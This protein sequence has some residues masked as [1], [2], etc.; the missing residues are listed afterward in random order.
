MCKGRLGYRETEG[1]NFLYYHMNPFSKEFRMYS[2]I[3]IVN[4]KGILAALNWHTHS[5]ISYKLTD[6]RLR[7]NF[8]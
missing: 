5:R 6:K 1:K 2:L 4:N 8:P 7:H 3:A